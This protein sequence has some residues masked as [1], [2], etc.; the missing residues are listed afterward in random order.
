MK[1]SIR[2]IIDLYDMKWISNKEL[3]EAFKRLE[4]NVE[5]RIQILEE[6]VNS[7]SELLELVV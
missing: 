5:K 7:S 3:A 4:P 1:D 2:K 6:N